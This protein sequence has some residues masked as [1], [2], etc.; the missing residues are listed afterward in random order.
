MK[1]YMGQAGQLAER[2]ARNRE[3]ELARREEFLRVHG[4]F[5]PREIISYLGLLGIPSQC[6][7]NIEP[8]DT[9]LC[10]IDMIDLE[11]FA[12][13]SLFGPHLKS[14]SSITERIDGSTSMIT[15]QIIDDGMD[16]EISGTS[17]MEVENAWLKAEL[18][19]RI[20]VLCSYDQCSDILAVSETN[21][22]SVGNQVTRKTLEAL[23]L[24]DDYAKHLQTIL[25]ASQQQCNSYEKRI[26]ELEQ[27]L[28]DQ[29]DQMHR[30]TSNDSMNHSI[31]QLVVTEAFSKSEASGVTEEVRMTNMGA[32]PSAC[33]MVD[34]E[35]TCNSH[36]I[37][38]R[39]SLPNNGR[40]DKLEEGVDESMVEFYAPVGGSDAAMSDEREEIH[41]NL[42]KMGKSV[43]EKKGTAHL[44]SDDRTCTSRKEG[45]D[46][47]FISLQNTFLEKS[48]YCVA[49]E[50]KL[51]TALRDIDLLKKEIQQ[52]DGL[53]EE[54][55]VNIEINIDC[56][57]YN[58]FLPSL[59]L[60][61][62]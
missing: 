42:T 14:A 53:L 54:C 33:V 44:C 29:H 7:V 41:N 15:N 34:H 3:A 46:R 43:M 61:K 50:E 4:G 12:P 25:T 11:K 48:K 21:D 22:P 52:K 27:R 32:T 39:Q 45:I 59:I 10:D 56:R 18:A 37:D 28:A 13:E 20:A 6:V 8:Y 36:L 49:L 26:R 40:M 57:I 19:S 35:E 51:E 30:L 62:V 58:Y 16:D 31:A 1:L 47:G 23:A 38:F 55:Q 9:E 24:K 60:R 5:I 17:K 2:M